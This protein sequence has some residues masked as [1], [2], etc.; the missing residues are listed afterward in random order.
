[1]YGYSDVWGENYL[2]EYEGDLVL[3]EQMIVRDVKEN[4]ET[5]RI[6]FSFFI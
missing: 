2:G 4:L 6:L 1:V 3:S 5:D